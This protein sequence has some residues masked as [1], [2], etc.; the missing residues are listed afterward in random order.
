MWSG[1]VITGDGVDRITISELHG[2]EAE[3]KANARLIAAAPDLLEACKVLVELFPESEQIRGMESVRA[4][5]A[6]AEGRASS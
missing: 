5:I 6:K 1:S 4:A 2:P 3:V